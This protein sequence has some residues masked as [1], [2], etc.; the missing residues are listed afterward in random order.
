MRE[1]RVR[2]GGTRQLSPC[3]MLIL[4]IAAKLTVFFIP[5]TKQLASAL[6]W[7]VL[8]YAAVRIAVMPLFDSKRYGM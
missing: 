8:A 6:L 2:G 7:A 3:I 1:R 4:H 5:M